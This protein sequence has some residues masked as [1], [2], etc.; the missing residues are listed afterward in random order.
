MSVSS[1][2]K[3]KSFYKSKH[4]MMSNSVQYR[5]ATNLNNKISTFVFFI[6]FFSL[7]G[8]I[9]VYTPIQGT[10]REK[11]FIH[12][13]HEGKMPTLVGNKHLSVHFFSHRPRLFHLSTEKCTGLSHQKWTSKWL[14]L[15]RH[16]I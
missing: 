9:V 1:I 11:H 13:I 3:E 6:Y 7:V 8:N 12:N 2:I 10:N 15:R 5:K 14:F 16:S 4:S